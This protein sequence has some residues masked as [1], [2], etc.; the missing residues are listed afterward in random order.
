LCRKVGFSRSDFDD[1][2]QELKLRLLQKSSKFD[3]TRGSLSTFIDRVIN[4]EVRTMLRD[5]RRR[6]RAPGFTASSLEAPAAGQN[7][8][9]AGNV[10]DAVSA[11]DQARRTGTPDRPTDT[12]ETA[13]AVDQ[14]IKSLP[15]EDADIANRLKHAGVSAVARDLGVSRQHVYEVI[16]RMRKRFKDAG[17]GNT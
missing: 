13:E 7:R 16:D 14:V 10:G 5:R 15:P 17:F 3:P 6:K 9:E 12:E 4:N 8:D 2:Q 1:L 11:A